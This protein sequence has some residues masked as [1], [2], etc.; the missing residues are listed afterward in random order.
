MKKLLPFLFSLVCISTFGQNITLELNPSLKNQMNITESPVGTYSIQTLAGGD[1]WI[2]TRPIQ[3]YDPNQV[4]VVSFDYIAPDGLD[5]L[6][7]FYG[8]PVSPNRLAKFGSLAPAT[9][10]KTFKAFMKYEA[11]TWNASY[12]RLRFDFGK[13]ANQN[14]TVKNVQLRA[15]LPNEVIEIELNLGQTNQMSISETTP[16]NYSIITSGG[17]PWVQSQLLTTNY[18]PDN[19]FVVSFD[20]TSSSGLDD[21]QIF[22]GS[23]IS[24]AR[25]AQLGSLDA[26]TTTKKFSAIMKVSAPSWNQSY[27]IFRFD[28]GRL[29]GLDIQVNNLIL[30]EP[31]NQ[32]KK[33]LEIKET[34]A[35]ELD[36]ASTSPFLQATQLQDGSYQLNTSANDPWILS[37]PINELYDIDDSYILSFEYKSEQAYNELELFYGPPINATQKLTVNG[38][39]A[40]SNWSTFVVNPRLFADNFQDNEWTTFR[41]DL[42]RNE[43]AEK[44]IFIRN[45]KLRKPTIQELENEQN[46]DKFLSVAIDQDF[47][48]YLN[49]TFTDSISIVKVNADIVNIKGQVL[50]ASEDLFLAE[51]EP[52][53]YG[54]DLTEF[55]FVTPIPSVDGTFSID[56]DRFIQKS[57]HDY[58]RLYSRWAIVKNTGNSSYELVSNMQWAG[59]ISAVSLNNIAEDKASSIKGLDGLSPTSLSNFS[60][61]T[62]LDIKSMKLNLLLNGVLSLNPT[63]LT[64]EFNGKTY[65]ISPNFVAGFD[66]RI[67]RLSDND[68]KAAFVLLIPINIGNEE[69]RRIFVHPD[70]SLGLYS[71]ANVATEEGVEYYAAAVDFL[72]QRYSRPDKLYG[73]LDQWIIH[74]EVDAH[75]SWTHAGQKPVNLYTQIYD[76]SMRMVNYTI[77][78]YNPTAKVFGSFTKHWNSKPVSEVNFRSK[79]ILDVLN[80]LS[81]KE[82]DYEW[83]IGWHSY[84]TNLFN[85]K[86]W[87]DPIAQTQLNFNTPQITPRNLE[88]IDA[89]VRQKE[90]LYNGK[91]VRTILLS[92]NGFSSNTAR[93]ANANETTQAAALA[94][95]WKKTNQRLPSIENIQLHRWVDNP[96]E[97]GL[98]FGLWTVLDGTIEGFDQ[99][100]EGWF[101]W[102]AAGKANEN[103]VFEP[104]KSV[105][106]ISEWSDIYN[107]VA[108]EVT[109]YI[110]T[111]NLVNC[112]SNLDELLVSFNGELKVPQEDGILVFYN[113]ASNVSQPYEIRKGEV[114][115]ASELLNI[116][117]DT[118][119]NIELIAIKNLSARGISPSEIEITWESSLENSLGF[120]LEA[121]EEGQN[122]EEIERVSEDISSFTHSNLTAGTSY[123]YRIAALLDETNLSCYSKEIETKAPFIIVDYKDGDN[124]RLNNN[125][126]K[127]QLKLRN[128]ADYAVDLNRLSVRYWLTAEDF[129]PL[130]FYVDYA[131][132]GTSD[133]NGAFVALDQ[134]RNGANYYLEMTFD[135][136]KKIAALGNSGEIKTRIAKSNWTNFDEGD[137]FSYSNHNQYLETNTIT[138][139]WD[140]Q[141]IW[142]NEPEVAT[143]QRPELIVMHQNKDGVTN[144]SMKPNI[145]ILNAGNQNV[146]LKDVTLRYWFTPESAITLNYNIDYSIINSNKINVDFKISDVVYDGASNYF[147]VSFQESTGNLFAFSET[148]EM[149]FRI[150]K[151]DWSNFNESDDFSYRSTGNVYAENMKITAYI[152]GQLVWGE[153]P[154]GLSASKIDTQSSLVS[155]FPNPVSDN[156]ILSFDGLINSI[157]NMI[158]VDYMQQTFPVTA[159]I[160]DNNVLLQIG[161]L[162]PGVYI[163]KGTINE[164]EITYRLL[165]E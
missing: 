4:Y 159:S 134:P 7:I 36:V 11:P 130:N 85:P 97:A 141:L 58:D 10:Y 35:I 123:T 32:E 62:E 163:L 54:F 15:A 143:I 29:S 61:L 95:F 79:E 114:I 101:V 38:I 125:S 77:R 9:Q 78:K 107:E 71:M 87:E 135:T 53:Q 52:H 31:T 84:P 156:C 49:K 127:P 108:T 115:L 34:I 50:N 76:R 112:N 30:R 23:P 27:D 65:N 51:I 117:E 70:A 28:F 69:L 118:E 33:A 157:G 19:T 139:Y 60:D 121:K 158:V 47:T 92:E 126:V 37:K 164:Q 67:K 88:M 110:V 131:Q 21:L 13:N 161:N 17:D 90:V 18:D 154:V 68:I 46:S 48:N 20:Y 96:N 72:A 147:E 120:V 129:S 119:I 64:H 103:T 82:G 148:G 140:G 73:R 39:P 162:N 98:E 22:Y 24:G 12:E 155:V 16:K 93:N 75:T 94:Y 80:R 5:D 111:M 86:V 81:K 160:Q 40:A 106:G 133:V 99:K 14:I 151:Q 44:T 55:N 3:N 137:D 25:R 122:F 152:N 136:N 132:L 150:N 57:D 104:Y 43:N 42:G 63:S 100:K 6:Q 142:G 146:P 66:A 1:P 2:Q 153:E 8:T 116:T 56:V 91:K 26:S 59:D 45:I 113:V 124:N 41:F 138:V 149:R 102:N 83:G 144:N 74:N 165:I 109:P 89:Y 105:I 145:R 128:E